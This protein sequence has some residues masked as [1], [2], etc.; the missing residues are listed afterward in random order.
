[1]LFGWLFLQGTG[2]R[3]PGAGPGGALD[4]LR[5][6]LDALTRARDDRR[7]DELLRKVNA[8][9][10]ASLTEGEKRFLHRM[11]RRKRWH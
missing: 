1:M 3:A 11:S 7:M 5:R 8:S 6:R 4:A 9:G 10:I 2:G